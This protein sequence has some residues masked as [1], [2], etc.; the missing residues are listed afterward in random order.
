MT[1]PSD[2]H[3][4]PPAPGDQDAYVAYQRSVQAERIARSMDTKLH[5]DLLPAPQA[6]D[7]YDILRYR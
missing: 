4:P 6:D 1:K 5:G 3:T 2:W 7:D